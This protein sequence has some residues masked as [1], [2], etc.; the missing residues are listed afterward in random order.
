MVLRVVSSEFSVET[1]TVDRING[2]IR[3]TIPWRVLHARQ[4]EQ[5]SERMD[6][7]ADRIALGSA[8]KRMRR[9]HVDADGKSWFGI[10]TCTW[11]TD[12]NLEFSVT[13][14]TNAQ[15]W[16]PVDAPPTEL[17][18]RVRAGMPLEAV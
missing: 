12:T 11:M 9:I 7:T 14:L 18:P 16:G 10:S 6:G 3:M 13:L 2:C 1:C 15:P 4:M 5:M 17:K 8:A